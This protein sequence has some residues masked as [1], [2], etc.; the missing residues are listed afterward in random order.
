M[1]FLFAAKIKITV[2]GGTN[3]WINYIGNVHA[4]C[5]FRGQNKQYLPTLVTGD[6]DSILPEYLEKLKDTDVKII[7]TLDQ[8]ATDFTKSIDELGQYTKEINL[9][10]NIEI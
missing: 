2:D 3:N 1:Y 9:I 7:H 8:N 5:L 10:V 6:M 4:S